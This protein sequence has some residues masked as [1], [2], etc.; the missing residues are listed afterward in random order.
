M[1]TTANNNIKTVQNILITEIV[2]VIAFFVMGLYNSFG[3]FMSIG[4][5]LITIP[6]NIFWIVRLIKNKPQGYIAYSI[7]LLL[8]VVTFVTAGLWLIKGIMEIQC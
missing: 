5:V 8:P 7:G 2:S 3:M 6:V 4:V 1:N